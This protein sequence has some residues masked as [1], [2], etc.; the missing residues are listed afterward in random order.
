M[1]TPMADGSLSSEIAVVL[2]VMAPRLQ[3]DVWADGVIDLS[4]WG[5]GRI[6]KV[7]FQ[8][9]AGPYRYGPNRVVGKD[10]GVYAAQSA[11]VIAHSRRR[12]GTSLSGAA[13]RPVA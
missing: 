2:P 7:R 11:P 13:V 10:G 1:L 4:L 3:A 12:R 5:V 9:I 8:P 6:A